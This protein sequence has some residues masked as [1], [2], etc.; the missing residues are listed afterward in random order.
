MM[1]ASGLRL[2]GYRGKKKEEERQELQNESKNMKVDEFCYCSYTCNFF[3]F[4][5]IAHKPT[6]DVM[7]FYN[8]SDEIVQICVQLTKSILAHR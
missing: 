7:N 3:F 4:L 2:A 6:N 8:K 1:M 5:P